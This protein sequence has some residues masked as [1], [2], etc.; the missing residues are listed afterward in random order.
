MRGARKQRQASEAAHS[1]PVREVSKERKS[2][3][4]GSPRDVRVRSCGEL[5]D[6]TGCSAGY[7]IA[8]K[9]VR[10]IRGCFVK[11]VKGY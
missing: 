10:T 3:W 2:S 1:R 6:G 5:G 11:D 4:V 9:L 8:G 7:R